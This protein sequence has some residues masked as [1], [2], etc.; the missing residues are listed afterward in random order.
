MTND[1]SLEDGGRYDTVVAARPAS[2]HHT[3]MSRSK[4]RYQRVTLGSLRA[5]VAQGHERVRR[6]LTLPTSLA[7]AVLHRRGVAYSMPPTLTHGT[8]WA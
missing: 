7:Q 1:G 5:F 6:G 4:F 8:V 3:K 2:Q